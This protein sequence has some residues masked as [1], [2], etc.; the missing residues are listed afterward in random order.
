MLFYFNTRFSIL[1]QL[2]CFVMSFLFFPQQFLFCR[3]Y[4]ILPWIF[5]F[6]VAALCCRGICFVMAFCFG[7]AFSF[8]RDFLVL[9]WHLC[10]T[11]LSIH[12]SG[13]ISCLLQPITTFGGLVK[14]C[15]CNG[16]ATFSVRLSKLYVFGWQID[17]EVYILNNFKWKLG[18]MKRLCILLFLERTIKVQQS[19]QR[20]K[21]YQPS[22]P[23]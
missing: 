12:Q 9:P 13:E 7:V 23:L 4:F 19:S 2:F 3:S 16:Q 5:H 1:P 20:L 10:V 15:S 17:L 11:V 8:C 18:Q 14:V 6:T 22:Q 21:G